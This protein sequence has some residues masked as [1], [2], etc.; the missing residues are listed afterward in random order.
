MK[1]KSL[2]I[3]GKDNL[4]SAKDAIYAVEPN[5]VLLA[6]AVR[7][8]LS[9]LRQGTSKVKTRSEVARTKKKWFKQKGTGNARH[10]SK[11]A[12]I[13][14]GGG[15][16][17]G[18]KGV[19]N[20]NLKLGKKMKQ[21]ALKTA[22]TLQSDNIF[23]SDEI[24]DLTGKTTEAVKLFEKLLNGKDK[25]L[26]VLSETKPS[27]IRSIQNLPLVLVTTADRLNVLQVS[28]ADKIVLEFEALKVLDNR[29]LGDK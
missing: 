12:P 7:I 20:W 11:N 19:E 4:I 25:V 2:T 18:P 21:S 1:L 29:L 5:H 8:Y 16:A 17:H 28:M 23:I 3:T 14:V 13:F 24:K 9:N 22:L 10:G 6:Q 26:V 27:A 15:V